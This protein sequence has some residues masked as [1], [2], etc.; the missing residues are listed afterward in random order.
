MQVVGVSEE[1]GRKKGFSRKAVRIPSFTDL[2]G[3]SELPPNIRLPISAF[4]PQCWAVTSRERQRWRGPQKP[5]GEFYLFF[6]LFPD[7]EANP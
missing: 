7:A 2:S 1:R 4:D 6:S 5:R 3:Q